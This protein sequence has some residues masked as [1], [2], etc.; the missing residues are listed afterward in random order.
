MY[1]PTETTVWS[2][3]WRVS[4]PAHGIAIGRPIANTDVQ[5]RDAD[6]HLCPIGVPGELCIGGLGL[7]LGYHGCDE[8]T[9][10]RFPSDL[11]NPMRARFYRTGDLGRWRPR[12]PAG[13]PGLHGPAR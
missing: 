1:G 10:E 13:T 8:L 4:A 12:R 6:G 5:V 3:V 11:D 9:A 7:A 2:T